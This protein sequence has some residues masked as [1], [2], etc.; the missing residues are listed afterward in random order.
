MGGAQ[1]LGDVNCDGNVN[2]DDLHALIGVIFGDAESPCAAADVNGDGTVDSADILAVVQLLN[3]PTPTPVPA[4]PSVTFFGLAAADGTML[5]PLGSAGGASVYFRNAGAGFQLVVEGT[6]GP[7]GQP[8]GEVTLD[9]DA[10]NP[11]QRPDLQIESNNPLGDGSTAVC[12]GGVPAINPLDF[13]PTQFIAN[14]LNDLACHFVAATSPSAACTQDGFGTARFLGAHTRV[15]FCAL[16]AQT[17]Q[18][19]AGDTVVSVRLRDTDGNLGALQQLIVR[20]GSGPA[21]PTFTPTPTVTVTQTITR[22]ATP[23]AR[24]SAP[25]TFTPTPRAPTRTATATPTPSARPSPTATARRSATVVTGTPT[26]IPSSTAT[27]TASA[28]PTRAVTSVSSVSAT[29]TVGRTATPMPSAP[30]TSS[31]TPSPTRAL[32]AVTATATFTGKA[33]ATPTPSVSPS[34][35]GFARNATPTPTRTATASPTWTPSSTLTPTSGLPTFTR[36]PAPTATP[37]PSPSRTVTPTRTRTATPTATSTPT[38]TRTSTPSPTATP[39][40]SSPIGPLVTF[41]GVTRGDD[42]LVSSSGTTPDGVPIYPRPNGNGF[43][44]VVE[45]MPGLSGAAVGKSAYQ[46]SLTSLPDL[47]VEV[48][49]PL[50]N[51]SS[52]VCDSSGPTP[53]GVPAVDPP[54]FAPTQADINAVN[55]LACRFLDGSGAPTGRTS[56]SCVL[57]PTGDYEFVNPMTTIQFCGVI[58]QVLSFPPG[59]TV[60]TARL[61]DVN[62]NAGPPAQIVIRVTP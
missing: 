44:L 41:F 18:F 4:G 1:L 26:S 31:F 55:D 2:S 10:K 50:G 30:P 60:V 49:N 61:R 6:S 21:P 42:T 27:A 39:T 17:L 40:S 25:P 28:T 35:T 62:G 8:P 37:T 23:T 19:P 46:P 38:S 13:G 33:T 52:A 48:S 7:S 3:P 43:S 45:S 54:N 34:V 5:S 57:F 9:H 36:T 15:Q 14:A 22:T 59:D 32:T 58:D 51:G 12:D 47:Q 20:V 29:P 24:P 11:T 53:G 56:D 16:V